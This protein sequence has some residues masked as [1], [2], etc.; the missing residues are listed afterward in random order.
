MKIIKQI[1]TDEVYDEAIDV[2]NALYTYTETD[3]TR[4]GD[5]TYWRIIYRFNIEIM[6]ITRGSN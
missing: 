3:W 6:N 5:G 1:A 4:R 2:E